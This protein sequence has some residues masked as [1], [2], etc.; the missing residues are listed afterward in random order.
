[1]RLLLDPLPRSFADVERGRLARLNREVETLIVE[2]SLGLGSQFCG[3][4]QEDVWWG[5]QGVWT[6]VVTKA[7]VYSAPTMLEFWGLGSGGKAGKAGR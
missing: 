4:P 7:K 6:G 2:S 1:M 3:F 5:W